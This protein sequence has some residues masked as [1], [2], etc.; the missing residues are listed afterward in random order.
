MP[1]QCLQRSPPSRRWCR[2]EPEALHPCPPGP[3]AYHP[4]GADPR[5]RASSSPQ[6]TQID[7]IACQGSEQVLVP[8]PRA[9]DDL[10]PRRGATSA[11]GNRH[12]AAPSGRGDTAGRV[13]YRRFM[14][15]VAAH[16][17]GRRDHPHRVAGRSHLHARQL[18]RHLGA[19]ARSRAGRS[20][21]RA[22]TALV[23]G[24]RFTGNPRTIPLLAHAQIQLE[25]GR[26]LVA[27][28]VIT[29][30]NGL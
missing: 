5:T 16:A 3:K 19:A 17:F 4:R 11:G 25:V 1:S 22:V 27:P 12:R 30:P 21:A 2:R 14:L 9:P 26:P 6:V 18:L 24:R 29:F 15:H 28:E 10:R 13:R 23:N 20:C 8:H 7:G